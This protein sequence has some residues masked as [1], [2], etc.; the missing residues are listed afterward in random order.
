MAARGCWIAIVLS[1]GAVALSGCAE[2]GTEGL[3]ADAVTSRLDASRPTAD[4]G[5]PGADGGEVGLDVPMS[6][7]RGS[8]DVDLQVLE[9]SQGGDQRLSGRARIES[10]LPNLILVFESGERVHIQG[11]FGGSARWPEM[12]MSPVVQAE[13]VLYRPFWSEA[14]LHLTTLPGAQP[15]PQQSFTAWSTSRPIEVGPRAL[16]DLAAACV[17]DQPCGRVSSLHL[18]VALPDGT[19]LLVPPGEQ[20][21]QGRFTALNGSSSHQW[22][23]GARCPDTPDAWRAGFV[24]ERNF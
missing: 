19:H 14:Q 24:L 9:P 18:S 7:A 5:L 12:L 13:L 6:C 22:I 10:W 8:A 15:F 20:V 1:A 21:Q 3:G 16:T 2:A 23:G 17:E 4:S 11:G